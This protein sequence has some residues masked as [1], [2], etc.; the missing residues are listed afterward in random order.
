LYC[1]SPENIFNGDVEIICKLLDDFPSLKFVVRLH[2]ADT[3]YSRFD[4]LEADPRV[5]LHKGV[6]G[7]RGASFLGR[8]HIEQ[9]AEQLH[10]SRVV[11]CLGSTVIIDAMAA[12]V[13]PISLRFTLS[14]SHDQVEPD[15][16]YSQEHLRFLSEQLSFPIVDS[17]DE[18][19]HCIE[20]FGDR[21]ATAKLLVDNKAAL[22]SL[23]GHSSEDGL[24]RALGI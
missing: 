10:A 22:D 15:F 13:V 16:W 24:F 18:L 2:P 11:V 7:I 21:V 5:L 6:S 4:C 8:A 20:K 23:I 1:C 17:Y 9:F 14:Q 19:S 3:D 12:G